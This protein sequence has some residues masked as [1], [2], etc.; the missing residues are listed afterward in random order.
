MSKKIKIAKLSIF[1]IYGN[2]EMV[3]LFDKVD[4]CNNIV[5][6]IVNSSVSKIDH[7]RLESKVSDLQKD[8]KK[9]SSLDGKG[10]DSITVNSDKE[11]AELNA[12]I[13]QLQEQLDI[14]KNQTEN[15][16]AAIK[17]LDAKIKELEKVKQP[18]QSP[19]SVSDDVLKSIE[20]K[21]SQ[22]DENIRILTEEARSIEESLT[23]SE[24]ENAIV[25]ALFSYN[26]GDYN[27]DI[28]WTRDE[29]NDICHEIF[30]KIFNKIQ[31]F[32]KENNIT[33]NDVWRVALAGGS[34]SMPYIREKI[35]ELF[36]GKVYS[37][38]D[39]STLVVKGAYTVAA[40]IGS[41]M[42]VN[43]PKIT[44]ILSHSLGVKADGL[45]SEMLPRY[46]KYPQ[47]YTKTFKTS[48]DNQ[49][50][51]VI[52]IYETKDIGNEDKRDLNNCELLGMFSLNN[53]RKAKK[54]EV[55]IDVTFEYD[56]SRILKVVARDQQT[57]I[58]ENIV[59]EYDKNEIQ[60]KIEET[61]VEPMQIFLAI[62][63]S[64]SMRL[65]KI[66]SAKTA[67]LNLVSNVI[68]LFVNKVGIISFGISS[69]AQIECNLCNNLQMLKNAIN[70][71]EADATTPLDQALELAA[72]EFKPN[73]NNYIILLTDG[74]P[75]NKETAYAAS[76]K[77][78][79][80][81]VKII[82]VGVQL[83]SRT[84]E[85]VYKICSVRDNGKPYLW[86]TDD[87]DSISE[88]FEQIIGEISE[89]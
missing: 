27:F 43:K 55:K 14:S 80:M 76:N 84:K 10:Y 50:S 9:I 22:Y 66:K 82:T 48:K 35:E 49:K 6:Q 71:I 88:I 53:I 70:Q 4:N 77:L 74:Y 23:N 45:F 8:I 41:G 38:E 83:N 68:D 56:D 36:P 86:L 79:K 65:E 32:M 40:S 3:E 52:E 57:G 29:F 63:A 73:E 16:V 13:L 26:G 51:V 60:N 31:A 54:G 39:L 2:D 59:I 25:P 75:D 34:C 24:E 89:L 46:S 72:K 78:K 30:D 44:D 11:V 18:V 87:I 20:S 19:P 28:Q 17:L 5:A 67:A 64:W 1:N 47:S 69:K 7:N 15:S 62:D 58:T 21:F 61:H 85:F 12:K 33:A 37:D 81:G 42:T